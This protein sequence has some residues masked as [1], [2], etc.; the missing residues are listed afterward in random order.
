M[1]DGRIIIPRLLNGGNFSTSPATLSEHT[2]LNKT[3][4]QIQ[5]NCFFV[6]FLE[7]KAL[8]AMERF[9]PGRVE[10]CPSASTKIIF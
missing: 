7:K 10:C 5:R 2:C 6:I 3:W 1:N 8:S 9:K 4:A